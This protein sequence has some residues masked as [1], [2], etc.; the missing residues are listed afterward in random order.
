M[1][2]AAAKARSL[3][4]VPRAATARHTSSAPD[5]SPVAA[6][7]SAANISESSSA[8]ASVDS[9]TILSASAAPFSDMAT[10]ALRR[11][12]SREQAGSA[13]LRSA[14]R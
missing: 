11:V 2:L 14:R 5:L 6:I 7:R 8:S 12:A 1:T 13:N 9:F 3:A 4:F 10:R